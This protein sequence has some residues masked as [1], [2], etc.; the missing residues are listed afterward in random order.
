MR[1]IGY[2]RVARPESQSRAV[3]QQEAK[4]RAHM[5]RRGRR[6]A[7]PLYVDQAS[8]TTLDRPAPRR[9]FAVMAGRFDVLMS[10]VN[11]QSVNLIAPFPKTWVPSRSST[12]SFLRT[13][14]RSP[15]TPSSRSP[16]YLSFKPSIGC[17][18]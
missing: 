15:W 13:A 2:I 11:W 17:V 9:Q 3:H 6:L 16:R 14:S 8:G 7:A 18:R 1:P 5:V 4:I 12:R 10:Y